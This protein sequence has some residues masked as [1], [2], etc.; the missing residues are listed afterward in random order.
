MV[1]SDQNRN[2]SPREEIGEKIEIFLKPEESCHV[3]QGS[4][5]VARM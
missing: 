4:W 5:H 3:E 1:K 2:K